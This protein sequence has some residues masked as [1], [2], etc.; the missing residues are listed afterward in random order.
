[1]K[2]DEMGMA[3]ST[4]VREEKYIQN[5]VHKIWMEETVQKIDGKI[6]SEWILGK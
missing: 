4:H 1:M 3:C 2:E 5:F 6:I